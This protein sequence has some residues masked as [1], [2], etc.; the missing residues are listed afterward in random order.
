M[1]KLNIPIMLYDKEFWD[2]LINFNK[3]L[4]MGLIS[5]ED[6]DLIHFFTDIDEGIEYL[7]PR[8]ISN[9]MNL[10]NILTRRKINFQS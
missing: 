3:F 10:D 8:L 9:M 7:K 4:D 5:P 1:E 6:L 2:D